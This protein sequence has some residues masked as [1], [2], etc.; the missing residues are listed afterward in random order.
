MVGSLPLDKEIY[1]FAFV[2]EGEKY[3]VDVRK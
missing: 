1:R 2:L 3:V